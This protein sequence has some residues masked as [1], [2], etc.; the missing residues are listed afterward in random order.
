MRNSNVSGLAPVEF[1]ARVAEYVKML[2]EFRTGTPG[3]PPSHDMLH[4][5][6]NTS[7]TSSSSPRD[8]T[9]SMQDFSRFSVMYNMY[10]NNNALFPAMTG[11]Q[12]TSPQRSQSPLP[13]A[14]SP[15]PQREALDLGLR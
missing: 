11:Q 14:A 10:N 6:N 9:I 3:T 5:Q 13:A 8:G 2:K 1:D 12:P 4:R 15:E 7:P